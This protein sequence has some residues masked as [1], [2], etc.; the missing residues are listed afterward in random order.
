MTRSTASLYPRPSTKPCFVRDTRSPPECWLTSSGIMRTVVLLSWGKFLH[1]SI[2]ENV[3]ETNKYFCRNEESVRQTAVVLGQYLNLRPADTSK[4]NTAPTPGS[5][6]TNTDEAKNL[7]LMSALPPELTISSQNPQQSAVS[8][9]RCRRKLE[10]EDS[11][12]DS[13]HENINLGLG[14]D[15]SVSLRRSLSS[16][17]SK[18]HDDISR[19]YSGTL[20]LV[21]S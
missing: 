15:P 5:T 13:D 16:S 8:E 17:M 9:S 3:T 6:N 4:L 20:A 11:S 14:M 12:Y 10:S 1:N 2:K 21:I 19:T 18:S 7:L